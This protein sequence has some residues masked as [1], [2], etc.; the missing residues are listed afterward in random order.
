[1]IRSAK[2]LELM[3]IVFIIDLNTFGSKVF[4]TPKIMDFENMPLTEGYIHSKRSQGS[5]WQSFK[6]HLSYFGKSTLI[7]FNELFIHNLQLCF[8]VHEIELL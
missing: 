8:S 2:G 5:C 7:I 6:M 3:K 4:L 1:M